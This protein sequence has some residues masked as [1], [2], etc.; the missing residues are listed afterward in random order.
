MFPTRA[1][2]VCDRRIIRRIGVSA[3]FTNTKT[4]HVQR[5]LDVVAVFLRGWHHRMS[6]PYLFDG[7]FF[8]STG[9]LQP[10]IGVGRGAEE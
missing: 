5:I 6:L 10:I 7:H 4:L 2:G 9:W 8:L 1:G 3:Y